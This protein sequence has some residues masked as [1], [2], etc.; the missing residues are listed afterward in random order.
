MSAARGAVEMTMRRLTITLL[1]LVFTTLP[2][3]AVANP[4]ADSGAG[5][6]EPLAAL[7]L[8]AG[9]GPAWLVYRRVR[10]PREG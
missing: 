8:L 9:A 2:L 5:S 10:G 7:L 1:A 4:P 6:P 3:V